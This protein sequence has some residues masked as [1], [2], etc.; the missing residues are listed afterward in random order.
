[1]LTSTRRARHSPTM[2][3]YITTENGRP[4][5]RVAFC[6]VVTP[7]TR[8]MARVSTPVPTAQNTRSHLGPSWLGSSM[9]DVKLLITSAPESADVT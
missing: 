4:M 1:M 2:I 3:R 9:R 5:I 8:S 6:S 7:P